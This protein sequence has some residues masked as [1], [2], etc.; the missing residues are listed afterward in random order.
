[1][2]YL[3]TYSSEKK[4]SYRSRQVV[5]ISYVN[6]YQILT[7]K[8]TGCFDKESPLATCETKNSKELKSDSQE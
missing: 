5:L 2:T 1:M 3:S 7:E 6:S 4:T 8:H